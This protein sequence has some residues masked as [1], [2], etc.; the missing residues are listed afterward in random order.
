MARE[1]H[2]HHETH[3]HHHKDRHEHKHVHHHHGEGMR[4]GRGESRKVGRVEKRDMNDGGGFNHHGIK[5]VEHKGGIFHGI[6]KE[7]RS[8]H[9]VERKTGCR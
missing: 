6:A 7:G 4:E 3:E 8:A 2:E 9:T 5:R 1:K